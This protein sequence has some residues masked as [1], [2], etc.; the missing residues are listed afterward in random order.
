M[1]TGQADIPTTDTL[2]A[3]LTLSLHLSASPLSERRL[4]LLT[5]ETADAVR[6]ALLHLEEQGLAARRDDGAWLCLD[7][8]DA[9]LREL[10]ATLRVKVPTERLIHCLGYLL[11][12]ATLDDCEYALRR[13]DPELK[14][15]T[16]ESLFCLEC[17]IGYLL[18]WEES[19]RAEAAQHSS[20]YAELVLVAQSICLFLPRQLQMA[21]RLSASAHAVTSACGNE[22][23][24]LLVT[25]F[26]F[27]LRLFSDEKPPREAARAIEELGDL[28]DFDDKDMQGRLPLFKGLL[29]YVRGEFGQVLRCYEQKEDTYGWKY[30]RF[31]VLLASCASQSAFYLQQ[32]HIALGINESCRRT[33]ALDGDSMLSMFWMLH[34]AFVMLRLGDMDAALLNLD[35]L[36]MAVPARENNKTS[37]STVRGIA[38]YH[39]LHGRLRQAHAL[40][41]Y[42]AGRALRRNLPH[43][44]FEDPLNLD[45]LYAFEQEGFPAVPRY[46]L[47][48]T[49]ERLLEGPNRQLRGAALRVAAL[50]LRD[51]GERERE[52]ALLRESRSVLAGTGDRREMA[53]TAHELATTLE[54]EGQRAEAR[55]LRKEVAAYA[56]CEIDAA[57]P[58]QKAVHLLTCDIRDRLAAGPH[59]AD[60]GPCLMERCNRAFNALTTETRQENALFRLAAIAQMEMKSERAA[61]FRSDGQGQ[62]TCVASVNLTRMELE[63]EAMRSCMTWLE[64]RV[65][66]SPPGC[67]R[68]GRN[69]LCLP[70]DIGEPYPWLLY[71]DSTFTD[72]AFAHLD[73]REL[74]LLSCLFASEVRSALRLKRVRDEESRHQ[75]ERFQSVALQEDRNIAPVFGGGLGPLLE[76]VRHVSVT[77]APVLILGETGV[78]K[79]V[80]ARQIHQMSRRCGPFIAVHPASTPESLFESEFF[81]YER[82][83]FTGAAHQK[84]G[85]FE[86]ADEGT[87]FIDE[88]GDIPLGIQVKLLRVLQERQF[89]RV[90][91]TRE[92]RSRFRLIAAT[93]K[94]LWEETE[95]GTFRE[96]LLYRISVV[97]LRLPPLR[98]RRE[99]I[100]LM[101]HSFMEHFSRRY[102]RP[103]LRLNR[104]EMENLRNYAWPGNIRELKNVIERAVILNEYTPLGK[105]PGNGPAADARSRLVI[106]GFPTLEE[107]ERRY[108]EHV[109]NAASGNIYGKGGVM[110][111]LRI[112]R[113]TLYA[114][115]KKHRLSPSSS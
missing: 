11:A 100:L 69:G 58:Y 24:R 31:A 60:A 7:V 85:F 75:K 44:P 86:M 43:A 34:L 9:L 64:R 13:L 25:I 19:H 109:L 112:K 15:P 105:R 21:A 74:R 71:L 61:L 10:S 27:Y 20:H 113:S 88:V 83:A 114:K 33:A 98:E 95:K 12:D 41:A 97:P 8:S 17:V 56:G 104:D 70:L 76:Q 84:I 101:A 91:G 62:L 90:G 5:G 65:F 47:E 78:G 108:L 3:A 32:Y 93:N 37:V 59:T 23:F 96:D 48:K 92:I 77:D 68:R 102:N 51:Q 54:R 80:M 87:L 82:G 6:R 81:G 111:R 1:L 72:G 45:M 39:Y 49:L 67:R 99:D 53:L 94:N 103:M 28:E 55:K 50:R 115:L 22:R 30:R 110:D 66:D 29:H 57:L 52:A 40:L 73:E 4:T 2:Y 16:P 35:C 26:S 89:M 42:H 46:H 107:L 38:L 79:E 106:D 63:S 18:R 14:R 36:F